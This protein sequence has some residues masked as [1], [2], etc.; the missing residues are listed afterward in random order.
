M[1][2]LQKLPVGWIFASF[3]N[4]SRHYMTELCI[5]LDIKTLIFVKISLLCY[6]EM[7]HLGQILAQI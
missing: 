4:E 2:A 3:R 1:K 5:A 7:F 6:K